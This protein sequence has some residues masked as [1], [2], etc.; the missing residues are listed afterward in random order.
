MRDPRAAE[1]EK[2]DALD[3][4]VTAFE[5]DPKSDMHPSKM[6]EDQVEPPVIDMPPESKITAEDDTE[7]L[8]EVVEYLAVEE[9]KP[10]VPH[11]HPEHIDEHP[12]PEICYACPADKDYIRD[13]QD[14]PTSPRRSPLGPAVG[15]LAGTLGCEIHPEHN[16][17]ECKYCRVMDLNDIPLL[18]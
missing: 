18:I 7:S 9:D 14:A 13:L 1:Q 10:V 8:P 12:A 6:A 17:Q 5:M 16:P 3:E 4:E 2:K 15:G 11:R